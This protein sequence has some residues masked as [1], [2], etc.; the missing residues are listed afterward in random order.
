ME[1]GGVQRIFN[2]LFK[3]H[4][5]IQIKLDFL[6]LLP[7]HFCIFPVKFGSRWKIFRHCEAGRKYALICESILISFQ[8]KK[9]LT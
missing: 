7:Q 8:M 3:G 2:L 4:I 1:W 5:L 6:I 9:M